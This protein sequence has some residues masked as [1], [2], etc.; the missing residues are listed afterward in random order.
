M[1]QF[2]EMKACAEFEPML[3]DM[4]EGLLSREEAARVSQH[5]RDCSACREALE[6]ARGAVAIV[7]L[8]H[9][10]APV[11]G[12]WF[13]RKV[14]TAI[15]ELEKAAVAGA[16]FWRPVQTLALRLAVSAALA[17][18][19]MTVYQLRWPQ[20]E[21]AQVSATTRPPANDL[22]QDSSYQPQTRDEVLINIAESNHGR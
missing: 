4:L 9:E 16:G 19:V 12:A 8:G 13:A 20:T 10:E 1:E 18:G 15:A 6:S 11:A 3:E 7:R 17:L 22:F 14:M 2:E 21:H 5:L